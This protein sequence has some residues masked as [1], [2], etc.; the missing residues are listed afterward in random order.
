MI[1]FASIVKPNN[2]I[3]NE[4]LRNGNINFDDSFVAFNTLWN[5]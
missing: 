1:N 2:I 4:K 5:F 3:I